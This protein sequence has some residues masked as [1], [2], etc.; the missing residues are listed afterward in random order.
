MFIHFVFV[1]V[2]YAINNWKWYGL[3]RYFTYFFVYSEADV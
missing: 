1:F 3:V 2:L